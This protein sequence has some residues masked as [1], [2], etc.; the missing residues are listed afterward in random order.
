M[1]EKNERHFGDVA[2][3]SDGGLGDAISVFLSGEILHLDPFTS[4]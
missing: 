4:G 2:G 3:D 1:T